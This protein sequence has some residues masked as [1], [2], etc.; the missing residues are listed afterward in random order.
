M[1]L[2]PR[3]LALAAAACLS[4]GVVV[5]V[6]GMAASSGT[7]TEPDGAPT[8]SAVSRQP[9]DGDLGDREVTFPR[10]TPSPTSTP[11]PPPSRSTSTPSP[12]ASASPSAMPSAPP[13]PAPSTTPSPCPTATAPTAAPSTPRASQP[14]STPSTP[15]PARPRPQPT[16]AP[17]LRSAQV[18]DAWRAPVLHIG[19]N[20]LSVPRLSSGARVGVTIACSPSAACLLRGDQLD[21]DPSARSVQVTWTAAPRGSWSGWQVSRAL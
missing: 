13:S 20:R 3:T 5:G 8:A 6:L 16:P 18:I 4:G 10:P 9:A 21:I 11:P 1:N 2:T 17:T 15:R 7:P 14:P 12:T 19:A